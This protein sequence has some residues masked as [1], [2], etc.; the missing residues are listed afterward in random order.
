MLIFSFPVCFFFFFVTASKVESMGK[1]KQKEVES[2]NPAASKVERKK[3]QKL[4]E[5]GS[6]NP[7]GI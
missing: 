4:K 6:K 2:K 7:A 3:N 1:K 5:G